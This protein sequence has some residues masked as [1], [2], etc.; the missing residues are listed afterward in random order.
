MA[1]SKELAKKLKATNVAQ[2]QV[3]R[4][5]ELNNNPVKTQSEVWEQKIMESMTQKWGFASYAKE[6]LDDIVSALG[7]IQT[8]LKKSRK[9]CTR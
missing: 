9:L 2:V 3:D 8:M 1:Q 5:R 4:F 7:R 6:E